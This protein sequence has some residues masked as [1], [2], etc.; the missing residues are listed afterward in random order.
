ME[1][2]FVTCFR[3]RGIWL[4]SKN[5]TSRRAIPLPPSVPLEHSLPPLRDRQELEPVRGR[6]RVK[7]AT[8]LIEWSRFR[9]PTSRLPDW[10][11][12]FVGAAVTVWVVTY[13]NY[14]PALRRPSLT[15]LG[16]RKLSARS[17]STFR[18]LYLPLSGSPLFRVYGNFGGMAKLKVR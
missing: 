6:F 8:H 7:P 15:W 3:S 2:Y 11:L 4:G 9:A 13:S 12:G 18:R 16:P 1:P 10:R 5:F 14:S 17:C